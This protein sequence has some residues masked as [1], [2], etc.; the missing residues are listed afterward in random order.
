MKNWYWVVSLANRL[1]SSLFV[2]VSNLCGYQTDD[3]YRGE[4]ITKWC[5]TA[6]FQATRVDMGGSPDDVLGEK[7]GIPVF[8]E[9]LRSLLGA[10]GIDQI[11]Y[12]PVDV[13]KPDGEKC[14]GFAIANI[15]SMVPAL[16]L[17]KSGVTYFGDER[18]DRKGEIRGIGHVKNV[19]LISERL[20]GHD[21]IRLKDF[22]P[23]I[24][25]SEDFKLAF[26][27]GNCSG[28]AFRQIKLS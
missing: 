16:D 6:Y 28:W 21:V 5:N 10:T 18:P 3:F 23:A 4:T 1:E 20:K 22:R 19:T 25:V 11:Q 9:R 26:D 13:V 7:N 14:V 17:E 15:L 24:Y 27:E 8:S 2:N 12:L